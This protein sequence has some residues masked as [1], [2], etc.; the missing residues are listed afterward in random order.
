MP[1]GEIVSIGTEL[2]L[3]EIQ[4][5]NT[6]H[7]ARIFR[8]L[9]IDLYRTMIV[10]DNIVRIASAVQ[11]AMQ[12]SD[13]I[14]T[15]GGLGPTVDDATRQA[16]ARAIGEDLQY[17]PEL[18][19]QIKER[20][21]RYGREPSENNRRQA[22]IPRGAVAIENPVGSAPAFYVDTGRNL[23]I[24][25]PG[26]PR[27]MDALL[28]EKVIPLLRSRFDLDQLI[29]IHVLHCAGIG[30]SLVDEYISEFEYLTNPTVGLLA[31]AG[32]VDIRITAKAPSV[33]EAE[34]IIS[35]VA[36]QIRER[37]GEAIFGADDETLESVLKQLLLARGWSLAAFEQ[38]LEGRLLE[39]L[40][41]GDIPLVSAQ[42]IAA[43]DPLPVFQ[44][45]IQN[46]HQELHSDVTIGAYYVPGTVSQTLSLFFIYP[47][48]EYEAT[49]IYGGPP[50]LG[51]LWAVNNTL[52]FIRRHILKPEGD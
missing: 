10:G 32:R 18:W 52:D 34:Q 42:R 12:R 39:I 33:Q 16:V 23:I 30:E 22:Y 31:D 41:R 4:D 37:M 6:I 19:R 3:G 9:G 14:L 5:T 43:S 50:Q 36:A 46:F 45:Q 1:I 44:K 47:T 13:I 27:E 7:I 17:H 29:K 11:E 40:Q 8:D 51:I 49:R 2:L 24:C 28:R 38:G 35:V 15:T 25:L 26:V 48:G 20:F 21:T